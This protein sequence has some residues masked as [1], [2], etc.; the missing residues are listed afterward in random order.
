MKTTTASR[1]TTATGVSSKQ[2][3]EN[4]IN[5]QTYKRCTKYWKKFIV[6]Y[7]VL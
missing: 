5:E 4:E 7:G 1:T 2:K 6:V 3:N